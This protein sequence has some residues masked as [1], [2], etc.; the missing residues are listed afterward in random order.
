MGSQ[1]DIPAATAVLKQ[2]YDDAVPLLSYKKNPLLALAKKNTDFG[3]KNKVFA[4]RSLVPQGRGPTIAIAQANKTSSGYNGFTVTRKQDFGTAT[5]TGETIIAAQGDDNALIEGLVK[6]IDGT[7]HNVMRNLAI[8]MFRNG[9]GARGQIGSTTTLASTT[10]TLAL[11]SDATNFESN[12][13]ICTA[14]DDGY[15]NGG[16]LLNLRGGGATCLT[17]TGVDADL[18]TLTVNQN[19]STIPGVAN[20]G[21]TDQLGGT[22]NG[23]FIFQAAPG[24]GSDYASMISGLMAWLPPTAPSSTDYYYG[25]NRSTMAT[26]LAGLRVLGKSQA[27]E[28]TMVDAATRIIT[29]GGSPDTVFMNPLDWSKLVRSLGPKCIY[30]RVQASDPTPEVG[31]RSVVVDGPEGKINVIADLNCPQGQAWMVQLDQISFESAGQ[32]PM[33]LDFDGLAIQRNP[34][35]DAYDVRVGYYGNLVVHAPGWCANIVW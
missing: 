15:N 23:D 4:V 18:G 7:I 5:I 26:R 24:V 8:C 30:E 34:N 17:V 29:Q 31:F 21:V 13:T 16:S 20:S 2:K 19:V 9:G 33:I 35:A 1:L 22:T 25:V 12:M 28:D 10:I 6:E 27:L 32:A 14:G 3:G 11:A